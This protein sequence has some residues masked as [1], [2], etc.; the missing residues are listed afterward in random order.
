MEVGKIYN[1]LSNNLNGFTASSGG[2]YRAANPLFPTKG[3]SLALNFD[4]KRVICHSTGYSA[5]M[6]QFLRE[7]S[8]DDSLRLQ[9]DKLPPLPFSKFKVVTSDEIKLPLGFKLI[10]E[11]GVFQQRAKEHLETRNIPYELF[12]ER[13]VGYCDSGRYIGSLII[14][15]V[16]NGKLV[17]FTS[18]NLMPNWDIPKYRYPAGY[19]KSNHFYNENALLY[20]E[21]DLVEGQVD[22]IACG[23]EG[24][25]IGGWKLSKKQFS[26]IVNS[27]VK[28]VNIIPDKG[29]Y[30]KAVTLGIQLKKYKTVYVGNLDFEE[31]KDVEQIGRKNIILNKLTNSLILKQLKL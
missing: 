24:V 26:K 27:P 3:K 15:Y 13:G 1:Y 6:W 10:S 17:L 7:I 23:D 29:F 25:G 8:G 18:R 9:I 14:P 5:T 21:I 31:N 28:R 30:H 11:K 2:W 20:D 12:E 16:N 4:Y 22:A 19:S